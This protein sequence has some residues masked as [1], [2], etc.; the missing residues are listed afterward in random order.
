M[1]DSTGITHTRSAGLRTVHTINF[2]RHGFAADPDC[3]WRP[4]A[5]PIERAGIGVGPR[6]ACVCAGRGTRPRGT[7][8]SEFLELSDD[9]VDRD[10]GAPTWAGSKAPEGSPDRPLPREVGVQARHRIHPPALI[11]LDVHGLGHLRTNRGVQS[12]MLSTAFEALA[13]LTVGEARVSSASSASSASSVS[14]GLVG[15]DRVRDRLDSFE[16]VNR[17]A[18]PRGLDPLPTTQ[19]HI[20][21]WSPICSEED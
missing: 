19:P 5:A 15:I 3:G 7:R 8:T 21:S 20:G 1:H 18:F 2:H 9:A 6:L 10:L 12:D 14:V 11:R 16:P 4:G 13:Q 17:S